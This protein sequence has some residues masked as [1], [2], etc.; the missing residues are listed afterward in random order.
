MEN[1]FPAV[2]FLL[3]LS[4]LLLIYMSAGKTESRMTSITNIDSSLV[5]N[6]VQTTG[7]VE[8]FKIS[9]NTIFV[10]LSDGYKSVDVVV[11]S[12]LKNALGSDSEKIFAVGTVVSVRGTVEEYKGSL[13][14]IPGKISDIRKLAV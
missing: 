11:F 9:G 8:S 3:S 10:R 14:I 5:G 4:G 1:R 7:Y 12:D 13:E 6:Y 2:F